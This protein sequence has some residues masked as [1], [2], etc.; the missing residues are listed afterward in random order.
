MPNDEEIKK[1]ILYE[2]HNT[3]YAMH[4]TTKMYRDLKKHFW[5][6]RMKTDVVEYVGRCLTCQQVKVEHKRPGGL[7]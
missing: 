2:V 3:P 4:L 1:Q 7:L 5:L 6:P